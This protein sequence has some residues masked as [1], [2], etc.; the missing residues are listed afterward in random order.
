MRTLPLLTLQAKYATP[1]QVCI[2]THGSD[3]DDWIHADVRGVDLS[4]NILPS[5]DMV[6]LIAIELPLLE[7]LAL[8][9]VV[10]EPSLLLAK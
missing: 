3:I 2:H 7:R 8:K 5:W 4:A 10:V 9:C 1:V 6:A